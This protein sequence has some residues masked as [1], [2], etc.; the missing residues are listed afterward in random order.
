MEGARLRHTAGLFRE[1]AIDMTVQDYDCTVQI[2]KNHRILA[3]IVRA[4]R[5]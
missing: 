3:N 4:S 5:A 1:A 2:P